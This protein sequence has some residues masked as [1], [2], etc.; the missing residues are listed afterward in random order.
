MLLTR[1]VIGICGPKFSGKSSAAQLLSKS[2]HKV[3]VYNVY[4]DDKK[5]IIPAWNIESLATPLKSGLEAFFGK[6]R[7]WFESLSSED[8][9]NLNL[10]NG[11]SPREAMQKFG[12]EFARNIF[13]DD[14]HIDLLIQRTESILTIIPDIR[15][16]NEVDRLNEDFGYE[17]VRIIR[18]ERDGYGTDDAHA[19]EAGVADMRINEVIKNNGNLK[20]LQN[21]MLSYFR[22]NFN[23]FYKMIK[24]ARNECVYL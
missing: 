4:K 22:D 9:E 21:K 8:K 10:H 1:F 7:G 14:I 11:V 19:S 23:D 5:N 6:H 18:L 13:G 16:D 17:N 3:S 12:T 15:F 20:D 24:T 2:L